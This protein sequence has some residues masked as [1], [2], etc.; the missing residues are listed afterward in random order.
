M[1]LRAVLKRGLYSTG[2]STILARRDGS[3]FTR[4]AHIVLEEEAPALADVI[5]LL[6]RRFSLESIDEY[7][8]ALRT[9]AC[10]NLVTLTFDDGLRNQLTPSAPPR[11]RISCRGLPIQWDPPELAWTLARVAR[12]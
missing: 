6:Q 2:V 7:L 4:A 5:R 12:G 10:R 11:R 3:S 9:G 1:P 8:A